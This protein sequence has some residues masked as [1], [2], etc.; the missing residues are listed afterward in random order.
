MRWKRES[1]P[2]SA[3]AVET[4][5]DWGLL[6]K[7]V[8]TEGFRLVSNISGGHFKDSFCLLCGKMTDGGNDESGSRGTVRVLFYVPGEVFCFC[9]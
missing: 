5:V 4:V 3:R 6:T 8:L 9:F 2:T 7:Q 1:G